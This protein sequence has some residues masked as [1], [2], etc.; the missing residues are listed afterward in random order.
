MGLYYALSNVVF[1]GATFIPKGGH[2][3]IEAAQQGAF[4]LHGP[5]TFNNPQLYDSL[6]SLGMSQCLLETDQLSQHVLPWLT[7]KK[8]SYQEPSVLK[9]YREKGL[10]DLVKLLDP[11]LKCLREIRE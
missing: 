11:H 6:A 9:T 2:N 7:K 10:L 1:M 8:E 5:Y 3:P 4:I